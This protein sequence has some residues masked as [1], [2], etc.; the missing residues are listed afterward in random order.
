[1]NRGVYTGMDKQ[2]EHV[3]ELLKLIEEN[4]NLRIVPMVDS[5]IVADDGFAWWVGSWGKAQVDEIYSSDERLYLR[6][7]DEDTLVENLY[8]NM[9]VE[10][11]LTDGEIYELAKKEVGGYKWEKVITV[12]IDLP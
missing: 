4:P 5:E 2:K 10:G 7:E 12:K 3:K 1:M 6:S 9:E 8:D 11:S